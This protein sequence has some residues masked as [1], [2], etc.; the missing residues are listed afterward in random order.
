M[1]NFQKLTKIAII[2]IFCVLFAQSISLVAMNGRVSY[3]RVPAGD[4]DI[5][6]TQTGKFC[7]NRTLETVFRYTPNFGAIYEGKNSDFQRQDK[8]VYKVRALPCLLQKDSGPCGW[9]SVFHVSQ[10]CLGRNLLDRDAFNRSFGNLD[11]E[12]KNASS[13]SSST[14]S[15]ATDTMQQYI[16]AYMKH[17]NNKNFVIA[18]GGQEANQTIT[19]KYQYDGYGNLLGRTKKTSCRFIDRVK[20]FQR[21]GTTQHLIIKTDADPTIPGVR[22]GWDNRNDRL[23]C[24][25]QHGLALKIEWQNPRRPGQC[26]AILSVADSGSPK[27]NRYIRLI[28]WYYH[29]FVHAHDFYNKTIRKTPPRVYSQQR[30]QISTSTNRPVNR[31]GNRHSNREEDHMKQLM[32]NDPATYEAIIKARFGKINI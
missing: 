8:N 22:L 16:S 20:E 2:S 24:L 4:G 14:P 28:H 9:Y 31:H 18:S 1:F 11:R 10:M 26:P 23:N 17:L 27:D 3:V 12:F 7:K 29:K 6:N 5:K 15:S 25:P 32:H 30:Q 13:K 21:K 19:T